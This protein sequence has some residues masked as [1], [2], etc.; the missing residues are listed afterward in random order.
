MST[1]EIR[2]KAAR[3][4]MMMRTC[5]DK[6]FPKIYILGSKYCPF[7]NPLRRLVGEGPCEIEEMTIQEAY[8]LLHGTA[9]PSADYSSVDW[10]MNQAGA[11]FNGQLYCPDGFVKRDSQQDAGRPEV[12]EFTP[13]DKDWQEKREKAAQEPETSESPEN[14]DVPKDTDN[15]TFIPGEVG[16]IVIPSDAEPKVQEDIEREMIVDALEKNKYIKTKTA[17]YLS[18]TV[19]TLEKRIK[20]YNIIIEKKK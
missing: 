16:G 14:E 6:R 10:N 9:M 5:G 15:L 3:S 1:V 2:T 8:M 17:V 11:T 18:M 19:A 12:V 20:K 13:M 7:I 4:L